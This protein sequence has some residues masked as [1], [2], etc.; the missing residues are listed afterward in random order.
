MIGLGKIASAA[1]LALGLSSSVAAD[2]KDDYGTVIGIDLGTTYSCVGVHKG[3]RV[4]IIANDQGNRITPSYVAYTDEERLVGDAAK[5]QAAGN[6]SNTIFDAKRMMG[7]PFDDKILQRD[8]KHFPFKVI[9]KDN[10]PNIQVE[11]KGEKK[12]FTP[13]EVSAMI[14]KKMKEVAE[15]YL[16]KAVT[17]AVVT[18]PAY[19]N[20]AQRQATKD[21]G[22]IA[23]LNV[24]RIINEPTAAAIAY[25][26]DKTKG[27]KTILVYDLGGGTFDVS[28]LSIDDGV[29]EVLATSGDTHLGGEDFDNRLID[30]FIKLF[31]KKTGKDCSKDLKAKGKL[32]REAEKAKRTLSSAMKVNIEIEIFL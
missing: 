25:G 28:L 8:L 23:G 7:R 9:A 30:H 16:G 11:F 18:V 17:H 21:A 32:K 12:T 20:D 4:E 3:G 19:F 2:A 29:F 22:T 1:V 6:P 26:L 10:K 13:E 5:N 31:K 24:L 27:E 15:A 14:L